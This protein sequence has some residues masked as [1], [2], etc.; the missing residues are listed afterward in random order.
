MNP[1]DLKEKRDRLAK[2][3]RA[4]HETGETRELTAAEQSRFD[5]IGAEVRK[6]DAAIKRL[7]T[8]TSVEDA[9]PADDETAGR[10][11]APRGE[12]GMTPQDVRRWSFLRA[13]RAAMTGR[14]REASLEREV[15]DA[16][17]RQLGKD[18]RGFFV[19]YDIVKA[20]RLRRWGE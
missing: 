4:L 14:W 9:E 5:E 6:V 11:A 20:P 18:A 19:P 7:V 2:E 3:L 17:A 16:V 10:R 8:L 12:L 1:L 15:S 13:C